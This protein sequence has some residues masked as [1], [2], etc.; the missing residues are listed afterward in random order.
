MTAV[1]LAL[2]RSLSSTVKTR[3]ALHI[4]IIALRHQVNVLKRSVPNRAQTSTLGSIVLGM[5]VAHLG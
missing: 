4:E 3:A 2:L 5:G 1:L